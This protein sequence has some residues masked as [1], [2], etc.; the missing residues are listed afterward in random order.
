MKRPL[1]IG[2]AT[3]GMLT[4]VNAQA[5]FRRPSQSTPQAERQTLAKSKAVKLTGDKYMDG[6][7]QGA[8]SDLTSGIKEGPTAELYTKRGKANYAA[9]NYSAAIADYTRA[10]K[11]DPSYADAH[12][13]LGYLGLTDGTTKARALES[14]DTAIRLDPKNADAHFG[15]YAILNFLNRNLEEAEKDKDEALGLD[16]TLQKYLNTN[17]FHLAR[18]RD[19]RFKR[20]LVDEANG[21][22]KQA[23]GEDDPFKDDPYNLPTDEPTDPGE[24]QAQRRMRQQPQQQFLQAEPRRPTVGERITAEAEAK[25]KMQAAIRDEVRRQNAEEARRRA[26]SNVSSAPSR[27]SND[28]KTYKFYITAPLTWPANIPPS[29]RWMSHEVSIQ[30]TS[31]LD[32]YKAVRAQYPYAHSIEKRQ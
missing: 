22:R 3:I 24:V 11:L 7:I 8:I 5:Q 26:A 30:A 27:N 31:S 28:V 23:K 21:L 6:D 13:G 14:F 12:A 1:S 25:Q 19:S 4:C 18:I 16:P 15:R 2:I 10:I 17:I 29:R 9:G 20:G 32:A